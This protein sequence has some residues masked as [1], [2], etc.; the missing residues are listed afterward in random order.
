MLVFNTHKHKGAVFQRNHNGQTIG[1][2]T[3]VGSITSG[4]WQGYEV[5][6]GRIM[7]QNLGICFD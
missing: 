6:T 4:S 5:I 7:S 2:N 3:G 1:S